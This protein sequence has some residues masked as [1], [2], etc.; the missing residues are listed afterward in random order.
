MWRYICLGINSS[1]STLQLIQTGGL[2]NEGLLIVPDAKIQKSAVFMS[3]LMVYSAA[4]SGP[5]KA[6]HE[7]I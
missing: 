7:G 1:F 3:K 2:Q 4:L 5:N 6:R